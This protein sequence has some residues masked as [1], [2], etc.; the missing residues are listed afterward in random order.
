MSEWKTLELESLVDPNRSICYGIVQPG[1]PTK[2]GVPIVR[3]NNFN[4]GQ[5]DT[6]E[7]LRVDPDIEQQYKRSRLQGGELLI[8][9]VGTMGL[10]A[11]VPEE[12]RGWNVARAVGV[13][14][15]KPSV[16]KRWINFVLRSQ[17]SQEFIQTHA[18][19]TV[20]AT[21]NLRDL[22]RLPVPM[23]PDDVR[24]HASAL[25]SALDDKIDL[26]RRMNETL[27][28]MARA[29]FKD[30]FVEFGPTRAK[31]EGREPY[32]ASDL[33]SLFPEILDDKGKPKGWEFST[34]GQEVDAVGGSTPSTKDI[35]FWDGDFHWATPKDRS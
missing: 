34:I 14:P 2:S 21:F 3:V 4:E 13:V 32:L 10:S 18:N 17:S 15:L 24:L 23:P 5:I 11:I 22:A 16:D 29:L 9:L 31:M 7:V 30:W 28:S 12:L 27:E 26:N 33:W 35:R 19:T 20:Q 1:K 25:L 8:T 6:R